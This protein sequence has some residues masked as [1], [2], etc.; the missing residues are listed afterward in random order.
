HWQG[1]FE[2]VVFLTTLIF[3]GFCLLSTILKLAISC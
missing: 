3:H 2:R 1:S